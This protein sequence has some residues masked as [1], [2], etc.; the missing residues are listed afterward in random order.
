MHRTSKLRQ[1]A[2]EPRL[3]RNRKPEGLSLEDLQTGLRRQFGREQTSFALEAH[4]S[5]PACGE[6]TVHNPDSG[7]RYRVAISDLQPWENFCACPD[8]ATNDLGTCKHIEFTLGHLLARRGGKAALQRGFHPPY[9]K[10]YLHYAGERDASTGR[11][12]LKLPLPESATLERAAQVLGAL[13]A[14]LRR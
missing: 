10:V 3:S 9:S 4:V 12:C 7:R 14:A 2:S 5:D 1:H 13:A 11:D 8:F 6:F